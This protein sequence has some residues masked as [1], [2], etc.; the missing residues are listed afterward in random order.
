MV[1]NGQTNETREGGNM[2]IRLQHIANP[3]IAGGYWDTP[4]DLKRQDIECIALEGCA[5]VMRGW[6]EYNGLGSGNM[7]AH[8]G[9]VTQ[10]GRV[11][12]VVSYNGRVWTPDE[13]PHSAELVNPAVAI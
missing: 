2:K 11:I 7:A 1:K 9:E 8:C 10:N 4:K 12:A 5:R 13:Y 3:D 6:V